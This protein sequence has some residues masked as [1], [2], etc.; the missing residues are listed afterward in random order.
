MKCARRLRGL[1]RRSNP[2]PGLHS[3]RTET[4]GQP[5]EWT[6]QNGEVAFRT[7]SYFKDVA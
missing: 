4:A 1:L 7:K 5:P 3:L 6:G 2:K